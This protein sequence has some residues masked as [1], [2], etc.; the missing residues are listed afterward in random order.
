MDV[1]A[2]V[3]FV[4]LG[5]LKERVRRNRQSSMS[6]NSFDSF[7]MKMEVSYTPSVRGNNLLTISGQKYAL[8]RRLKNSAYWECVKAR[9][10][11]TKCTARVITKFNKI[12]AL[13]REHNH[14]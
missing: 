11:N 6:S 2:Y 10:K 3:I 12:T 1:K 8:N 14:F 5:H 9:C 4:I 7:D 13:R